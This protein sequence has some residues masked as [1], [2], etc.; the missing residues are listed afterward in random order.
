MTL[1]LLSMVYSSSYI[2]ELWLEDEEMLCRNLLLHTNGQL[3]LWQNKV[4]DS[5][6]T[7]FHG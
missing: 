6:D 4:G 2:C 5:S 1:L 7:P 3:W